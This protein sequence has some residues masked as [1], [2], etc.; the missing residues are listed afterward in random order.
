MQVATVERQ[1]GLLLRNLQVSNILVPEVIFYKTEIK[2]KIITSGL[3]TN[4]PN[5]F[6]KLGDIVSVTFLHKLTRSFE[7]ESQL[8]A[9]S[10]NGRQ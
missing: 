10:R 9:M 1:P 7:L 5:L 6:C 4:W 8:P 3:S 2:I